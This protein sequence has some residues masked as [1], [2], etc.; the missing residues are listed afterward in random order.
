[1][2]SALKVLLLKKYVSQEDEVDDLR[3][4]YDDVVHHR[5]QLQELSQSQTLCKLKTWMEQQQ[6]ALSEVSRTAKLWFQYTGYVDIIKAFG[7][8]QLCK[9]SASVP[10]AD[11]TAAYRP[12]VAVQQI[13]AGRLSFSKQKFTYM[14][15]S[16]N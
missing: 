1:M 16:F 15:W 9:I 6:I 11:V 5:T 7:P 13:R 12:P 3:N 14:V 4:L 2:D 8:L 10:G